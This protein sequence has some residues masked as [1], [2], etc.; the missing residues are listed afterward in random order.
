MGLVDVFRKLLAKISLLGQKQGPGC[1]ETRLS[2]C[3]SLFFLLYSLATSQVLFHLPACFACT[4]I[5]TITS[6]LI[7]PLQDRDLWEYHFV[8]FYHTS[9]VHFGQAHST[10]DPPG[11]QT[12][13]VT[14][15]LLYTCPSCPRSLCHAKLFYYFCFSLN[16]NKQ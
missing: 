5:S 1:F 14:C 15:S 8:D 13:D 12:V 16:Q 7:I 11:P 6:V 2:Y 10:E 9:G 3:F 4:L